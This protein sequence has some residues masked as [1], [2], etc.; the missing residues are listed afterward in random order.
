MRDF[1]ASLWDKE[2]S[3]INIFIF[4]NVRVLFANE[5]KFLRISYAFILNLNLKLKLSFCI[6]LSFFFFLNKNYISRLF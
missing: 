5:V 2:A 1:S 3:R 6:F 4:R